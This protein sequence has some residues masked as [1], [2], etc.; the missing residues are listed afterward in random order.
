MP[1]SFGVR[2]RPSPKCH[3]QTRLAITRAVSRFSSEAIHSASAARGAW[4]ACRPARGHRRPRQGSGKPGLDDLAR[5]LELAA[6]QQAGLERF[7]AMRE[8]AVR[9]GRGVVEVLL[10]DLETERVDILDVAGGLLEL[11]LL[12]AEVEQELALF[13]SS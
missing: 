3:C 10:A 13:G 2:T 7:L 1:K 5:H 4:A 6:F 11:E 8:E 12:P 9:D